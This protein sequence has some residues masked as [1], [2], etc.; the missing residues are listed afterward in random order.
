MHFGVRLIASAALGAAMLV[1]CSD[2]N[3]GN[4]DASTTNA[5]AASTNADAAAARPDAAS[6]P[7]AA[8]G[9]P[10][11]AVASTLYERLGGNAGIVGAIDAIVAAEVM[12]PE[13]AAFFAPATMAGHTPSVVQIKECLVLQVGNAAGG[14]EQYPAM[15][16]GGF[17]CRTMRA[18]HLGLGV[19][20]A[21]FDKFVMIAANTLTTAGVAPADVATLGGVLNST[22]P[23]IVE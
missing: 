6:R 3:T 8:V 14:P 19:S 2:E 7:D 9:Q 22:K 15:V 21:V 10:D 13:I 18:A 16:S 1:A 12:D 17:T 23:D 20:S 11:A 5:D 4:P